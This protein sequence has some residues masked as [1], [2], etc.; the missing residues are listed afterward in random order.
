MSNKISSNDVL[1]SSVPKLVGNPDSK[2]GPSYAKWRN[3]I[4][5]A[6]KSAGLDYVIEEDFELKIPQFEKPGPR[7]LI[8]ISGLNEAKARR[9]GQARHDAKV[10]IYEKYETDKKNIAKVI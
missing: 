4:T 2:D 6:I 1:S 3:V 8:R 10:S 7:D 9:E 5:L